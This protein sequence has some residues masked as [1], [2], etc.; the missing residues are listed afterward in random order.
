MTSIGL[1]PG[2][3][4]AIAWIDGNGRPCAVKMP[5]TDRDILDILEGITTEGPCHAVLELVRSSPQ[6]GVVSAYT[7][8]WGYGGLRMALTA[9]RIPFN[10]VTPPVWMRDMKCLTKGDKT[11]TKRHA[12]EL[13]PS[14][15]ITNWNADALLIA[16]HCRRTHP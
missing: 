6:M 11:V 3:N 8:G 9:L 2:K 5:E 7:F 13:F 1:D 15:K 12:Q 16:E 10:E 14:L 4:G